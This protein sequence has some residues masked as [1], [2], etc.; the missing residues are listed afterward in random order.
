MMRKSFCT[1]M[2]SFMFGVLATG[3]S[4]T[5]VLAELVSRDTTVLATCYLRMVLYQQV[6]GQADRI[7]ESAGESD[8][9]E[10]KKAYE[11]VW[12][13]G[14]SSIREELEQCFREQSRQRFEEFVARFEA[15]EKD[16][17]LD[18]LSGIAAS[19]GI[20]PVPD[21]YGA[22]R[23]AALETTLRGSMAEVSKWLGEVQTWADVRSKNK[24]VPPLEMWL[25][26]SKRGNVPVKKEIKR[27]A[28]TLASA[29]ADAGEFKGDAEQADSP[30]DSFSGLRNKKREKVLQEAQAGMQ[31]VAAERQAAETEYAAKKMAA[32][33]ADA[34][35]MKS[36]AEK[37][38]TAEKD[39]LE[40]RQNSFG[41][42]LKS[43]VGATVGAAVGS[44]T[45]GIGA[46]A[47]QEA[48]DA[49]FSSGK[50]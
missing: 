2:L 17:N 3:C 14:T 43:I 8:R 11:A 31:Q 19:L 27:Q 32:A 9:P 38:A 4:C 21:N 30:L 37:L 33:Q 29:E 18:F 6:A 42:K 47:G 25:T 12:E 44:F 22:L 40:Q 49:I 41:A 1:K 13:K 48:V 26:R 39:A 10:I 28:A 46:R 50:K 45:G 15:A 20:A 36:Q 16:K 35:A 23:K 24:D 7:A 5:S 34:E